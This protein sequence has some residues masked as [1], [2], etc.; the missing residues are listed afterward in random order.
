MQ[1]LDI[2]IGK[3]SSFYVRVTPYSS[4]YSKEVATRIKDK[5][6]KQNIRIAA[7]VYEDPDKHWGAP[8]FEGVVLIQ[9]LLAVIL[10]IISVVLVYNTLSALITQQINQIGILKAIGGKKSTIIKV[11]LASTLVYGTLAFLIALPLGAFVAF[12]MT[13]SFLNLFNIDF[14]QFQYSK[15]AVIFQAVFALVAPLFAGLPPILKGAGISVRQAITSIGLGAGYH[16]GWLDRFI[17]G[18]GQRW[19][20]TYYAT[21]L[22]NMFRNKGRLI[23]TQIV[24][25]S[26]GSAFLIVMS[27][28]SSLSLTLDNYF[29]RL[30]YETTLEFNDNQKVGRIEN[31]AQ[32]VQ[33]VEQVQLNLVQSASM[34][35]EGQLVKEAGIGT[36]I[37]GV[38]ENGDFVKPLIVAGRWFASGDGSA[39]VISRESAEK[40]RVQ[41]GDTVKLDLGGMGED[42]WIV[43]GLYEPVFISN[44]VIDTIYAPLEALYRTTKKSKQGTELLVRTTSKDP[45][46]T[47]SVTEKLKELFEDSNIKVD[48][49]QTQADLRSTY[50]WQFSIVTSMLLSLSII[51]AVV[52]GIALMGALSIGV[53]ERTKEIGVLRA[54]GARSRIILGMFLMEGILQGG[55]SWLVSVPIS[56]LVS[57]LVANALGNAMFSA[58]LDYQFNS[59][60][61][62]VWLG[63]ILVISTLASLLPARRAIRISVSD[64]LAYA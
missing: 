30:D 33:G 43:V 17:G 20:P 22:G 48:N 19:L 55:L 15:Q 50:E 61:V 4:D 46:F 57:P 1:R 18:I 56:F 40:N 24:L 37:K 5:L 59:L 32:T 21:S 63:I 45:E 2:P 29:Q 47:S 39:I 44:F 58:S 53:I 9:K 54:V 36:S 25:I 49:T 6:G 62:L 35:S 64:S 14:N 38:P 42:E 34:F 60:A 12:S 23:M 10:V 27:L 51:V 3:F 13:K 8:F 16:S 52:G 7:F 28:T 31:L 11:Y 41:V 26:A